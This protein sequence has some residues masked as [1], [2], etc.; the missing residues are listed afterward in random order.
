MI[1]VQWLVELRYPGNFLKI[2]RIISCFHYLVY[3]LEW[4]F[5]Q[6]LKTSD[7]S[8]FRVVEGT[9]YI[10]SC[11]DAYIWKVEGLALSSCRFDS[12]TA[13]TI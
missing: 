3:G 1:L 4:I 10:S 6:L 8:T 5:Q 7:I 12:L 11:V 13:L 2:F 9:A